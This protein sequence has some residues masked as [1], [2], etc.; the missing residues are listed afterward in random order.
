MKGAKA[1]SHDNWVKL[2]EIIAILLEID[3]ADVSQETSPENVAQW[4]SLNHLN[5]CTAVSQ[6]FSITIETEEMTSIRNVGDFVKLLT[7]KGIPI[8]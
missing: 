4:D 5:I 1:V 8:K 2:A 6:E 7:S 3:S